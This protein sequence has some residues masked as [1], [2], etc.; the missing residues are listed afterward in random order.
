[1][2]SK[3]FLLTLALSSA[4]VI[5][6]SHHDLEVLEN[7]TGR[8]S[9][10]ANHGSVLQSATTSGALLPGA[11]SGFN[12]ASSPGATETR[13]GDPFANTEELDATVSG[14]GILNAATTATGGGT[15]SGALILHPSAAALL[16]GAPGNRPLFPTHTTSALGAQQTLGA[17]IAQQQIGGEDNNGMGQ[18]LVSA[19]SSS[20]DDEEREESAGMA[21]AATRDLSRQQAAGMTRAASGGDGEEEEENPNA[22]IGS[23][24]SQGG[25]EDDAEGM[26][27][28]QFSSVEEKRRKK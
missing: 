22:E 13:D 27:V 3:N 15:N 4:A 19:G 26:G 21:R 25:S 11:H 17:T 2:N 12:N 23:N 16:T 1:M 18:P 10:A 24:A 14:A 5:N 6:A 7:T 20:T 8:D 9:T 28:P